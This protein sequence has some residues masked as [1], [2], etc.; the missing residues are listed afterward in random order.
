M[1][2]RAF[3]GI[4]FAGA[5]SLAARRVGALTS[6]GALAAWA[7]GAAVVGGASHRGAALLGTFFVSASALTSLAGQRQWEMSDTSGRA[8]R[9]VVANGGVAAL[10]ALAMPVAGMRAYAACAGALATATADTWA[11]EIGAHAAAPPRLLISRRIVTRGTSGAVTPLGLLGSL[12]GAALLAAVAGVA[13]PAAGRR[14]AAAALAAGYAGALV[15]SALGELVQERLRCSRCGA[16]TERRIHHCG[17]PSDHV[18]GIAGVTND[19]VNLLA[20]TAGACVA[21]L[22]TGNRIG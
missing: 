11:T 16:A 8:A 13:A 9:Q 21:T 10:A 20:T 5:G 7:V 15:D 22:L 12:G 2:A 3:A 1:I 18:G 6:D 4:C 19:V 17:A 14:V